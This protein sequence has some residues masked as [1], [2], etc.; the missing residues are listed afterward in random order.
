[1]AAVNPVRDQ[2]DVPS[3]EEVEAQLRLLL[4][5]DD[6]RASE[7][8]RRFLSYVVAETLGGRAA[9]LKAYN[10]ALAVFDRAHD[11]DPVTD[12]IV[13]I[14]GS[15]LRRALDR[16]YSTA[17]KSDRIRID[18]PKGS[19]SVTF[20]YTMELRAEAPTSPPLGLQ[21][22]PVPQSKQVEPPPANKSRWSLRS[23]AVFAALCTVCVI[24]AAHAWWQNYHDDSL[25][26]TARGPSIGVL[27]FEYVGADLT[28]EFVWRTFSFQ[29]IH[30][31]TQFNDL[32]V[33]VPNTL[34]ATNQRQ[35]WT[36]PSSKVDQDF[37][38]FGYIQVSGDEMRVSATLSDAR[39]S[40]LVW[41]SRFDRSL[42]TGSLLSIQEEITGEVASAVRQAIVR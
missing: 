33:L 18:M 41:S 12:P 25:D 5:R 21:P 31:L 35:S 14:E 4:G 39:T 13:R 29:I 42:T 16:Y 34:L 24:L 23:W 17:G 22:V 27:P 7:R 32:V 3:D 2:V 10:I 9:R 1:V 8:N 37:I 11:F 19:Y 15:R 6:F 38:L 36:L 20:E 30:S 40:K 26:L 28:N